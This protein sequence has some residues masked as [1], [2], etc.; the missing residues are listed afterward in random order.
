MAPYNMRFILLAETQDDQ[1]EMVFWRIRANVA[2]IHVK[3]HKRPLF[4]IANLNDAW[5]LDPPRSSS[6]TVSA[7]CPAV[8]RSVATADGRFS[9]ILNFTRRLFLEM[10]VPARLPIQRRPS[11]GCS[12]LT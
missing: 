6:K 12:S 8:V 4:M 2:E 3:R 10:G 5:S 7:S 1:T 9:S 11:F